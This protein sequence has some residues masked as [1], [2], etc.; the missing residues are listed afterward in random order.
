MTN[1]T[2][3]SILDVLKAK[4]SGDLDGMNEA[5]LGR[6]YQHAMR[7]GSKSFGIVSAFRSEKLRPEN[8]KAHQALKSW[9][10]A[11]GLGFFE[12]VGHW[13]ECRDRTIAYA[14]CPEQ[15]L[16]D[17]TELTLF[18]PGIT[19][20]Q[21]EFLRR[22]YDQDATLYSGPDSNGRV[23]ELQRG[24]QRKDIGSFSPQSVAQAYSVV[25]GRPFR[26]ESKPMGWAENLC[27]QEFLRG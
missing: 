3:Y 19:I 24:G 17:A 6:V 22:E 20:D 12:L 25:K 21:T 8:L 2:D 15:D 27:E 23:L 9:V 14:D 4:H 10:R 18:I 7:A 11:H 26:F 16:V 13:R 1:N 5:S